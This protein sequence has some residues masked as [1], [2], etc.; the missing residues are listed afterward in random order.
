MVPLG[1]APVS[2]EPSYRA[3]GGRFGAHNL[4]ENH[5][6]PTCAQLENTTVGTF[7]N[8]G[9]RVFDLHD[10]YRI[11]ELAYFVPK[12]P[13]GPHLPTAQVNDVF[14]DEAGL[15]YAVERIAGGLYI[16]E[17]TGPVALS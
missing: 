6:Q 8:G 14:V 10:P 17:Y 2:N 7:F 11:E 15:I 16:L 13:A 4:H 3:R 5:E 12:T 1:V 9:V